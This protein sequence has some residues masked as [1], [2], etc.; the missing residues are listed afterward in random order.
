MQDRLQQQAEDHESEP[1][2]GAASY[3]IDSIDEVPE[4]NDVSYSDELSLSDSH[5]VS[6]DNDPPELPVESEPQVA[7]TKK[8]KVLFKCL[9]C[10][11]L[12]LK[13]S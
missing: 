8:R 12:S 9:R 4:N 3:M 2:E 10:G 6:T 13:K 11:K 7:E 5:T 1:L